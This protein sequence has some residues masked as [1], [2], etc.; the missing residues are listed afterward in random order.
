MP[1]DA[2]LSFADSVMRLTLYGIRRA[3]L[4][5]SVEG[6]MIHAA[7]CFGKPYRIL[8]LPYSHGREWLPY[9]RTPRQCAILTAGPAAENGLL[10]EQPAKQRFI[11]LVKE[12]GRWA[13]E[14]ALPW[15]RPALASPDRDIR[16]AAAESLAA[17]RGPEIEAELTSLLADRSHVVRAAA[18][19]AILDRGG[20]PVPREELLAHVWIGPTERT[21]ESILRL[22]K[23]ARPAVAAA[24]NGDDPVVRREAAKALKVLDFHPVPPAQDSQAGKGNGMSKLARLFRGPKDDPTKPKILILTP[25]KDAEA[26]IPGYYQ[27]ISRLTYPGRRISL[28]FLESDSRDATY[29]ELQDRLPRL[30]KHFRRAEVW[31]KD[32]GYRIPEGSA[33]WAEHLQ[34]ERRSVL[35][36]SRNHLLF[37]ALD[38]EDWVLWL[39]VDVIEYP[40]NIL[41]RLLAAG[42]DILQP[43]CVLEY[44]GPSFDQNAWRDHGK[45]LMQHM[46]DEGELVELHAVGGTMLFVRADAHREGLIFPP[47]PYGRASG[48]A[49]ERGELET[50]GLGI[51]AR[52]MGYRCWGM[53]HLEIK[54]GKW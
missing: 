38:D 52:E 14:A 2:A 40:E 26:F 24:A 19:Q 3:D 31:K 54:H 10:L 42:K 25:V 29:H 37:H 43:H 21:W 5:V 7:H 6:W 11:F 50:E 34:A 1:A 13:S 46:R 36:K 53:P 35:A 20:T 28:G 47:A 8:M 39:D 4:I 44:G 15:I 27:R 18:A 49:R 23:A 32:F 51:M 45:L 41:E 22:R 48:L 16:L 30:R 9:G 17:F 12:L 33:R